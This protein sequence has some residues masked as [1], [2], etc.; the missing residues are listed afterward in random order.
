MEDPA[1]KVPVVGH[2]GPHP[3]EYHQ[4]V[5]DELYR[6]TE[7]CPNKQACAR[8]LRQSLQRLAEEILIEGRRL[9]RLLTKGTAP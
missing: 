2:K 5:Y 9:N 1:N 4:I 6:A 3:E 7:S 8:A